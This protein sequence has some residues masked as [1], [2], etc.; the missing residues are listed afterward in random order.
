S[1]TPPTISTPRSAF[2]PLRTTSPG[3]TT[4]PSVQRPL[5][6][7]SGRRTS[8]SATRPGCRW[9]PAT[10]TSTSAT[11]ARATN[12]RRSGSGQCK[13]RR[14]SLVSTRP[15]GDAQVMVDTTTGQLGIV[16]SSARYKQ[17]IETMA[18]RS[19]GLLKLRPVTFAYKGDSKE[20][21]HYGLIAEE[22]T[23]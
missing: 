18:N 11:R 15:A 5:R 8:A 19:D 2:K 9:S 1:P 14:S 22:V 7:A 16:T 23:A 10:T 4:R 6:R 3:T 12:S 13:H 17:D 21:T 20:V